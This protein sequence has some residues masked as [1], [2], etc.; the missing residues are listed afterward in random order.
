MRLI[1][2]DARLCDIGHVDLIFTDPP[3]EMPGSELHEI[4]SGFEF[5]HLV[6]ICSMHQAV[7]FSKLTNLDFCFDLVISHVSPKKSKSY[8]QPNMLHSNVLYFRKKGIKPAFDRRKVQRHDHYSD[9]ETSRYYPSIFHAPK[10]NLEYKY[11][12]N[13]NTINDILGCFDVNS[14]LDPFAGAGTTGIACIEHGIDDF[15]LIEKNAD[16]FQILKKQFKL[17][18]VV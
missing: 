2:E 17:L 5:D 11:Q 8:N 14:V 13:Q 4:L 16:A 7:S 6:L 12:K 1:N 10:H 3:F 18:G 9:D 15:T